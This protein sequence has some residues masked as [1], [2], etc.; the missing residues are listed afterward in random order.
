MDLTTVKQG[1]P[2]GRS[3]L[4]AVFDANVADCF[5]RLLEDTSNARRFSA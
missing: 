3:A 5:L 1:S 4:M 2:W